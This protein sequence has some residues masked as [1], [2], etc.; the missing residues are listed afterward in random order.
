MKK[1]FW[2]KIFY[3][4][5]EFRLTFLFKWLFVTVASKTG[6]KTCKAV[7][8]WG[9]FTSV[10]AVTSQRRRQLCRVRFDAATW[11]FNPCR[12]SDNAVHNSCGVVII[13]R[14]DSHLIALCM[15]FHLFIT[16]VMYRL[17]M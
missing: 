7:S 8:I 6:T 12:A 11:N 1:F 15:A 3:F 9:R 17:F 2:I 4:K 16:H 5:F 10:T 14:G 13:Q